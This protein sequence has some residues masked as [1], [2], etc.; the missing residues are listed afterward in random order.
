MSEVEAQ[1]P[2]ARVLPARPTARGMKRGV[3][4]RGGWMEGPVRGKPAPGPR[5]QPRA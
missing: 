2:P 4:Q 3:K 5:T 1:A